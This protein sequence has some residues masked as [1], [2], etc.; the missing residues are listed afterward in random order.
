MCLGDPKIMETPNGVVNKFE[1]RPFFS[2]Y[3]LSSFTL[4]E[5]DADQI[6][7]EKNPKTR[8]DFKL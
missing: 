3:Y 1:K 4:G 6:R 7:S 2:E 8:Y 5:K